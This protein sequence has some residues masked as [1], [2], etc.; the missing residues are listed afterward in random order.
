MRYLFFVVLLGAACAGDDI[1]SPAPTASSE[2]EIVL[3]NPIAIRFSQT[4]NKLFVL[5]SDG[6][7][8]YETGS[9]AQFTFD[10]ADPDAPTLSA[11][12]L[13][14]IEPFG[15]EMVLDDA[16]AYITNRKSEIDGSSND[17]VIQLRIADGSL[18]QVAAVTVGEN[19]FGIAISNGELFVASNRQLDRMTAATL[20]ITA[21][22]DLSD[23]SDV[24][25]KHVQGVAVDATNGWVFMAN[26]ADCIL[27]I[28]T[29]DNS[30]DYCI[31]GPDN[32]RGIAFGNG[33]VYVVE[34]SPASL[35][36][37]DTS[38]LA[39]RDTL[40]FIDDSSVLLGTVPV[41]NDPGLI[42]L[43]LANNRAYVT[44]VAEDTVSVIDTDLLEELARISLDDDDLPAGFSEGKHPFGI[45]VATVNGVPYVFVANF[46]SD[47][48]AVIRADTLEVVLTFPNS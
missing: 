45:D 48:L 44:N 16:F 42:A 17:R 43:D 32:T 15:S 36:V 47:T 34:G 12:V 14:T 24:N 11:D 35:I 2:S 25:A 7:G 13:V 46:D 28:D 20:G 5:N 39:K 4:L 9:V 30:V 38:A 37:L 21:T 10:A 1:F 18:A 27:V 23:L 29:S 6:Q 33:R 41:G 8:S 40:G 3:P 26:R 22:V 19:P 31:E